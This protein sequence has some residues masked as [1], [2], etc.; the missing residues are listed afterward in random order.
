[1]LFAKAPAARGWIE[2]RTLE[3]VVTS[4]D[5]DQSRWRAGASAGRC[6]SGRD[7]DAAMVPGPRAPGDDTHHSD[8]R[9]GG[10][11]VSTGLANDSAARGKHHG[12]SRG[13]DLALRK[14]MERLKQVDTRLQI[15]HTLGGAGPDTEPFVVN[16]IRESGLGM[17]STSSRSSTPR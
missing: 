5:E 1:L 6:A 15:I 16:A 9:D 8:R 2:G 17:N 3:I 4:V 7:M 10:D 11:P 12:F 13:F 14:V